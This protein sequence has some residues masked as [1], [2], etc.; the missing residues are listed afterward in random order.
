[1]RIPDDYWKKLAYAL[2]K[3]KLN[4]FLKKKAAALRHKFL[5]HDPEKPSMIDPRF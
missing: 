1:M 2:V 3:F 4:Q 5:H